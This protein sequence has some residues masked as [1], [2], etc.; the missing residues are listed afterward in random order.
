MSG[1]HGHSHSHTHA[2][3]VNVESCLGSTD[4]IH[5]L[6]LSLTHTHT[7][8]MSMS[9]HVSAPRTLDAMFAERARLRGEV[10]A[11]ESQVFRR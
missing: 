3:H 2:A 10:V 11:T 8:P 5:T 7:Q 9:S 1:L 4:I 6:S